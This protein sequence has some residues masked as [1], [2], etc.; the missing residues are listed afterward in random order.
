MAI[1]RLSGFK[2]AY[3]GVN[4]PHRAEAE[5]EGPRLQML[6][7]CSW[8]HCSSSGVDEIL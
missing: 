8:T 3:S 4:F 7:G 1:S 6:T 5:I 2:C